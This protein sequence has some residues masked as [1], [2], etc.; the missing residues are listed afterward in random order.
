MT[1]TFVITLNY[2]ILFKNVFVSTYL[3][4]CRVW[5]LCPDDTDTSISY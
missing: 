5:C 1:P 2:I 4:Q 3:S